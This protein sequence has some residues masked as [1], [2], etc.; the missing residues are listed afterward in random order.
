M[1]HFYTTDGTCIEGLRAARKL[2]PLPLPSPTT[3]LS[4]I[5]GEGLI[6][7]FKKMMW[8]ATAT[9]PRKPG[10]SDDEYFEACCK[11]AEEHSQTA[12][13]KGGDLHD[14]IQQFH[15]SKKHGKL[16]WFQSVPAHL[17]MAYDT[18]VGWYEQNVEKSLLVEEV[19][20]G[21]GYAGRVDHVAQLKDG[22]K[23]VL[24]VKSQDISKRKK[25]NKYS[26][27]G[28]QLGAYA[29]AIQDPPN[30]MLSICLSSNGAPVT[31]EAYEWPHHPSHYFALFLGL[32]AV[33]RFENQYDT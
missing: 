25:F 17:Q 30:V 27:W 32:L 8:E 10:W 21:P 18:Y 29:G 23:A 6:Y 1:S 9:T 26:S 13:D 16:G 11:W 28:L 7:Y 14:L 24:D 31:L 2:N 15:L 20:F 33:W 12:R 19:V 22:R 3:V 5:K 4:L